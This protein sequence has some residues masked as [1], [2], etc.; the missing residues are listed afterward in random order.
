MSRDFETLLAAVCNV[1]SNFAPRAVPRRGASCM[2]AIDRKRYVKTKAASP[3]KNVKGERMKWRKGIAL[4]RVLALRF[5]LPKA[6]PM[7][8]TQNKM[9]EAA[10]QSL[11]ECK[12]DSQIYLDRAETSRS[13]K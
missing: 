9:F 5:N 7:R 13:M 12:V 11:S 4:Q 1:S 6:Y 8:E 10:R 3:S 2:T